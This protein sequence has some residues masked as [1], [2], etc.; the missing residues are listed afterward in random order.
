MARLC[1][2]HDINLSVRLYRWTVVDCDHILQQKVE[3]SIYLQ[4][5]T[6]LERSIL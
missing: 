1:Y 5:E 2:E 4:V 3:I 6:D